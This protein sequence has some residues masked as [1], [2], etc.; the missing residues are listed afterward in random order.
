MS[1]DESDSNCDGIFRISMT[2]LSQVVANKY[3]ADK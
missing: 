3:N 1:S 2:T